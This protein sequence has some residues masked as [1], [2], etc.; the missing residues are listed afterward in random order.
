[1][2]AATV[3]GFGDEWATF[4]QSAL[5]PLEHR[6]MF[7]QYFRHFPLSELGAAEGFDLGSGSGRWALLVAPHVQ[8]LHCIDPSGKALDVSKRRLA[9]KANVD[10]HLAG[11]HEI[12]L[13]DGSQD[14]GY[15]LGVLHHIP[16]PEKALL[17]CV[18]KLRE[19]APFLLYLYY[20][21]DNRPAWFRRLWTVTDT[22][23][24]AV[25][26]LPFPARRATAE[27]IALGIY[28]P[29]ARAAAVAERRGLN[30]DNWPLSHY[31]HCSRY[32][33]RTDALDRFG[34]RI[35]HRFTRAEVEAM[36][37]RAGLSDIRFNEEPPFWVALGRKVGGTK[38]AYRS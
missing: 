16:N 20:R 33:M 11:A 34:T 4:D 8:K 19:G 28:L 1:M 31:R 2:D 35:E 22:I 21:F 25:S 24:R 38:G 29:A 32:T 10:F 23:R 27:M 7:N 30:I 26:R 15:S 18:A 36:M 17:A 12:P 9:S 14:F 6:E 37:R 3:E 13:A 5:E